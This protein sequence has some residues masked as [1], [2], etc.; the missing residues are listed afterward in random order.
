MGSAINLDEIK[1]FEIT[2][3]YSHP[4][5]KVDIVLVHGLNGDPRQTWTAKNGVF[6]PT[7]LLPVTLK[8]VKARILVY[9]YN[10]DVYA[11]GSNRSAS[12]D[13][14]YQHAQ[15]LVTNLAMER[16]NEEVS[17]HPIIFVAHSLGGILVKRALELS[18]DLTSRHADDNRSIYISTYGIIFLGT[19]HTGADPAK[20]GVMLES[21]VHSL[22]PRKVMHSDAQLVKTL[23]TNNE[24]LQN[25][26]LHFLDIYQRFR[27]CM[28]HEEMQTDLK[29][30]KAFI[31]DQS[32]A[33]PM[34]P[35]VIYFGIAASH[36]GM[37]KFESKNSP[38][39]LNVSTTLKSWV[40]EA[41]RTIQ[42]RI[43]MEMKQR[44]DMR[45][46]Q[47]AELLGIYNTPQQ[48]SGN[49]PA[50]SSE[51]RQAPLQPHRQGLVESGGPAKM[52]WEYEAAEVEEKDHEMADK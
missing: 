36:S 10:A 16:K 43:E 39:Y 7:E 46:A 37:C 31:V 49:T 29:G 38:G 32:S 22:I 25:I 5:A 28:A 44:E 40:Q 24:T 48:S 47:A 15:S 17:D 33:S 11:F 21:M 27:I 4:E 2:E 50:M 45:R 30:T 3:V 12:S 26:N 13:M 52:K 34:L 20:W 41:P 23:Q 14:I 9:G 35:D 19:P 6:W 8:S 1:R 51:Y 42:P 18:N